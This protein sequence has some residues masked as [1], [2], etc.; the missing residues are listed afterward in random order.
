MIS[1]KKRNIWF[2]VGT[3]LLFITLFLIFGFMDKNN[4]E[5][6]KT[7]GE[8]IPLLEKKDEKGISLRRALEGRRSVREYK[9]EGVSLEDVSEVVWAAQ[10]I[11]KEERGLRTAPSAGATYPLEIYLVA[12]DVDGL[13]PGI[14]RFLPETKT[15]KKVLEGGRREDLSRAAL[16]QRFIEEAPAN[17]V[18][19]AVYERTT[20]RYG[21]R[22]VKYVHMEAGHV[23]QNIYL[24]C[25][26]LGLGTVA[27]G[28]FDD[29]E[30]RSVL[31]LSSEET[32]LY[33]FPLGKKL[34]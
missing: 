3:S 9:A 13:D 17:I 18:I 26:S 19:T 16:G 20:A 6:K 10:G 2:L 27:V 7:N 5:D 4:K 12:D 15:F 24:Q 1:C 31:H 25:E 28:A 11:T 22:G 32:P 8:K 34:E 33:I 30:M 14:Y 21:E 29:E 23:G